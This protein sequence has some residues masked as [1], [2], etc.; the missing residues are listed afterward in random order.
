MQLQPLTPSGTFL[1][2]HKEGCLL[3]SVPALLSFPPPKRRVWSFISSSTSLRNQHSTHITGDLTKTTKSGQSFSLRY[4]ILTLSAH[5]SS[6][7]PE[8]RKGPTELP[9]EKLPCRPTLPTD[10]LP[11]S[12][13]EE[14]SRNRLSTELERRLWLFSF[15]LPIILFLLYFLLSHLHTTQGR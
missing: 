2:P 10:H 5:M 1:H 11:G 6:A 9:L 12:Q 13:K 14:G 8:A 15:Y 4:P 7:L 3:R